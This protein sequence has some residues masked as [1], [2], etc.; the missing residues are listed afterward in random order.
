MVCSGT[1]IYRRFGD[2]TLCRAKRYRR[3]GDAMLCRG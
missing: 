2:A 3:F 1:R